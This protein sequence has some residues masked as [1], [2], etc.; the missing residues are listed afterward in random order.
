MVRHT[1]ETYQP[2]TLARNCRR[3]EGLEL[4][5]MLDTDLL[6]FEDVDRVMSILLIN[7][8][9]TSKCEDNLLLNAVLARSKSIQRNEKVWI[10]SGVAQL[11]LDKEQVLQLHAL[12]Q[13]DVV[14]DVVCANVDSDDRAQIIICKL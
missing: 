2:A 3:L 1:C 6:N 7:C 4:P 13:S 10:L 11:V 8:A 12:P 14:A 5:L 9:H